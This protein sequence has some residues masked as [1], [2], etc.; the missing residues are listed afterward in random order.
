MECVYNNT[1]MKIKYVTQEKFDRFLVSFETF[2]DELLSSLARTFER[3]ERN[4]DDKFQRLEE[5]MDMRFDGVHQRI[6]D[7]VLNRATKIEV[8]ALEH[9]I[10]KIEDIV[11]NST[12]K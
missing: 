11:N 12:K 6:D 10:E 4:I 8:H 7:I 9:R 1:H 2:K 5:R 3:V